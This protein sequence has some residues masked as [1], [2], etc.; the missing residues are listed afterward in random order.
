MAYFADLA[1]CGYFEHSCSAEKLKA[2][3]WLAPGHAYPQRQ[4]GLSDELFRKLLLL[5]IDPWEP[6]CF[7]GTHDCEF[8]VPKIQI[9]AKEKPRGLFSSIRTAFKP[10]P[11]PPPQP[12]SELPRQILERFGIE[13]RFGFSNLFVP[14]QNCIFVA[15]SMIAHYI[16]AHKYDPPAEFW[17]AVLNCPE[18]GSDAYKKA[19]LANGPSDAEW[20]MRV[21]YVPGQR[22]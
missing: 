14:A 7:L 18:M 6:G 4:T 13:I 10:E 16:D 3:G 15:P 9:P 1:N 22:H 8:C 5:L 11:Q 21:T 12:P 20:I 19:L 17:H 2:V